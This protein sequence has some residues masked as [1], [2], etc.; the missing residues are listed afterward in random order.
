MQQQQYSSH[1]EH[2]TLQG[3]TPHMQS[4]P[5]VRFGRVLAATN[6]HRNGGGG[7]PKRGIRR[8]EQGRLMAF[9]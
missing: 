4:S 3:C 7:D 2:S 6:Y 9:A 5:A 8:E 1:L